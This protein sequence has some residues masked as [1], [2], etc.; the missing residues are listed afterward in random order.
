MKKLLTITALL[1][2]FGTAAAAPLSANLP[3]GALLTLETKNAGPTFD[4]LLGLVTSILNNTKGLGYD[5][6]SMPFTNEDLSSLFKGSIGS[7]GSLGVYTVGSQKTGYAPGLLAVSKVN[8][9][10]SSL[11]SGLIAPKKGAKVGNYSFARQGSLYAGMGGGLV[12]LS[13]DKALLTSYLGRLSGKAGPRLASS[14]A[15]N[16]PR[17]AVG[18]QEFGLYLNFSATAKLIRGQFGKVLLPRLFSPVVDALDT[19]GQYASG[20]S[21]SST[22]LSALSAHAPNPAGLDTPLLSILS[23]TS[24]FEVQTIIPASAEAVTVSACAPETGVYQ[25]AWLNRIDL[26]DPFGF[27]SD[28]QLSANLVAAS[29][30]LGDE[31]AQVRLAGGNSAGLDTTGAT[32]SDFAVTYH[33]VLD[34]AAAEAQMPAYAASVNRAIKGL[35]SSLDGLYKNIGTLGEQGGSTARAFAQGFQMGSGGQDGTAQLRAALSRIKLVYGFRGDY[36][37]T[38]YSDKALQK[39][40][41]TSGP[42]LADDAAFTAAELPLV[43]AAGWSYVRPPAKISAQTFQKYFNHLLAQ[44]AGGSGDVMAIPPQ[45][46]KSFGQITADLYN[47]FGGMSS[48][49]TALNGVILSKSSVQYRW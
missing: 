34:R 1:A 45:F 42:V 5:S 11:F 38:A 4:R 17:K 14:A 24:N 22:G 49:S 32:A 46:S 2:A 21:S 26:F 7:E 19:L 27:L 43:D 41:S 29:R 44:S 9:T 15:Y 40:L 39:A 23:H 25:A 36:L 18:E 33:K 28:S 13:S 37:I 48:Q 31:C 47:R 30:Y 35:S 16:V 8:S 10:S 6:E 12:Y 3:A 20:F